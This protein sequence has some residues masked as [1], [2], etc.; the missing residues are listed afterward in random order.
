MTF[1]GSARPSLQLIWAR[2]LQATGC[3]WWANRQL[4]RR[5]AVM[6]LTFHRVLNDAE[7]RLTSSLPGIVVRR[8]TFEN[9]AAYVAGKFEAVDFTQAIEAPTGKLRVMFTL[10]DGWK[11]NYTDAL[12]V[13]RTHGIPATAFVCPGLVGR[14]L[15]FWPELIASLLAKTSPPR[16]SAEVESLIEKLKT[17]STERRQQF[18]ADLDAQ[19]TPEPADDTYD[20]DRTI[21]WDEI[22]QMDAA[23]VR[24][25]CHTQTHQILTNVPTETARQEIRESKRAIEGMLRGNCAL[26]A[27]PNGNTSP[28]TRRILAE[29]GFVAAFTTE[30]GAWTSATDPMAIPR[31]NVCEAGLVGL[32]GRF[33]PAMFQYNV[34]WRAWRVM[35]AQQRVPVKRPEPVLSEA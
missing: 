6:V 7:F 9:L 20:G 21:T 17:Y 23:G 13:M 25:G 19:R 15:P 30:R 22:K 5:G 35:R 12:P 32:T 8:R 16:S 26:F 24:F 10:D 14:A 3:L 11:D 31:V 18:I 2:V 27:Y 34:F 1:T 4:R 28:A 29:E 33:S